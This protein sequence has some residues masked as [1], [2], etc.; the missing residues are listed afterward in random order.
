MRQFTKVD[1]QYGAPM[2]R[3]EYN[4][5]PTKARKVRLYRVNLDSGG[6]DDGGAY[7]GLGGPLWCAEANEDST[8]QETY[9]AFVRA[10]NR[11]AAMREL[12]LKIYQLI[13][14]KG[15]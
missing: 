4:K 12:G 5:P 7:W 14:K 13:S 6:Y 1:S 15:I 8:G 10:P 3:A 9:R 2:G 11:R